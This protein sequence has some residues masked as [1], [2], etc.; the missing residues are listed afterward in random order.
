MAY[1]KQS[2]A[3]DDP[4][5]PLSAPRLI[6]IEDGIEDAHEAVEAIDLS[7]FVTLEDLTTAL[8]GK[9]NSDHTHSASDISG[10]LTEG[11][12]PSL[13]I[14]K[15][16]GLQAAID[17]KASSSHSHAFSDVTGSLTAAQIPSL[18]ISKITNL[19]TTLDDK[20]ASADLDALVS[21]VEALEAASAE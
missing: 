10:T 1:V 12:V 13:A 16:T 14:S 18:A 11:Q 20:A 4:S 17:G 2:W 21:R 19:Q 3:N 9:A 6:H 5:T 8:A 7:S 15:I